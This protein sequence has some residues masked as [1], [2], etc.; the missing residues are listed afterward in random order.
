[1]LLGQA[2]MINWSNVAP[3]HRPAYYEWHSR[4]HMVGRVAIPGFQRGRRYIARRA[5]RDFLVMYEVD[6]LSVLT[7]AAYLAKANAP[8]ALTQRTTPFIK[9][10]VRG[11]ARV[12]TSFGI[13]T[14][15][16]ALTLRFDPAADGEDALA[17]YLAEALL[18]AVQIPEVVGA[19]LLAADRSASTIVPVEREG[20]PTVIPNWIV[21]IEGVSLEAVNHVGDVQLAEPMLSAHGCAPGIER[22][23]YSLQIM[24][25]RRR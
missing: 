20:R 17:R 2:A 7:S 24:V 18:R 16:C 5:Q 1:M 11:L 8:S 23:T 4:E 21:L 15:G 9:N 19:H 13:G 12:K 10:S 22:D 6:D 3:K 14:G 25:L